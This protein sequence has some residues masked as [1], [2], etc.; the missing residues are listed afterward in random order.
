MYSEDST[1][2]GNL[3]D[4]ESTANDNI[5]DHA[6]NDHVVRD[7]LVGYIRGYMILL[8]RVG[9]IRSLSTSMRF[10]ADGS[11]IWS[12]PTSG[13]V[14]SF[15]VKCLFWPVERSLKRGTTGLSGTFTDACCGRGSTFR[16]FSGS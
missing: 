6:L 13:F 4:D 12:N 7:V 1:V 2:N 3:A 5:V 15:W 16:I 11:L 10:R 8:H 9:Q 14:C